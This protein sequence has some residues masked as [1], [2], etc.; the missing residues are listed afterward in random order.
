MG[1]I[2]IADSFLN[3]NQIARIEFKTENGQFQAIVYFAK[4]G[5][6]DRHIIYGEDAKKLRDHMETV[7]N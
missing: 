7:K 5:G 6:S 1:F 3:L 4:P 2:K